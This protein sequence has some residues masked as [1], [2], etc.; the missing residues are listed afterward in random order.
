MRL[1]ATFVAATTTVLLN[2]ASP[3]RAGVVHCD[4]VGDDASQSCAQKLLLQRAVQT[5]L[6]HFGLFRNGF[7]KNWLLSFSNA[8]GCEPLFL[9]SHLAHMHFGA[10]TQ[11]TPPRLSLPTKRTHGPPTRMIPAARYADLPGRYQWLGR[12]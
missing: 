10:R 12:G 8:Q 5:Q 1:P 3:P 9:D 2:V 6:H 7:G 11:R 4:L